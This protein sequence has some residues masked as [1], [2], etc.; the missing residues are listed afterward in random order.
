MTEVTIEV[1]SQ[2]QAVLDHRIINRTMTTNVTITMLV[3]P[4]I[5][6]NRHMRALIVFKL[7]KMIFNHGQILIHKD[8]GMRH[9]IPYDLNVSVFIKRQ[10]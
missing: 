1:S 3:S 2:R 6:H 9:S 8:I 4:T 5:T 7:K 10:Q